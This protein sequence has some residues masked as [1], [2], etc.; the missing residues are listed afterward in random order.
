[1]PFRSGFRRALYPNHSN[2]PS[3]GSQGAVLQI[4]AIVE[5]VKGNADDARELAL[6]IGQV[7][8]ATI[9]PLQNLPSDFTHQPLKEGLD[10]FSQTLELVQNQIRALLSRSRVKRWLRHT[11]DASKIAAMKQKI[12]DAITSIQLE[13]SF[14]TTYAVAQISQ[15]Q[16]AADIDRLIDR[17]GTADNG[18]S[19]KPPCLKGTRKA[20]L[21]RIT[22]WIEDDDLHGFCPSG[23]AGTGK[24]SIATSIAERE[25]AFKR[26]GARFHFTRDDQAR[27]KAA[28]IVIARQ[29]AS[30][31]S[32]QLRS[33]I[34]SAIERDP[35]I[36]QM[37]PVDQFQKLIMGPLESL[38]DTSS[39]LVVILG[40]MDECDP[41]YAEL[42]L[43][44]IGNAFGKLSPKVKF[45]IASR[46]E[47]WLQNH[48]DGEPMKSQLAVHSL[49]DEKRESVDQDIEVFLKEELPDLVRSLVKDA[50]D[51]PGE[52][53]RKALV[54]KSQGLFIFAGTAVR[55]ITDS[56][57]G[58]NPNAALKR[59]LLS[60]NHSHLDGIHGQVIER[61]C[62]STL[63][64]ETVALFRQVLGALVVAREPI[65]IHTLASLL[66]PD[67]TEL[68]DF[69]S[70][71]RLQVLTYLQA[72]LVIPDVNTIEQA[73][74]AQPIQFIHSSFVDYLTDRNRSVPQLLVHLH[75]QHKNIA[76]DCFRRMQALRRNICDLDPSFLN[77]EVKDLGQRIRE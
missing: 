50:S 15:K 33:A 11:S 21:A 9:R 66:C 48:Y 24:S 74:D 53:K 17:L 30:W 26:L 5:A 22:K 28:I 73:A 57:L 14:A 42:L 75:K 8:D 76:I 1:M 32:G 43:R 55:I 2:L 6:Y 23:Q 20:V 52:A 40:A 45:F 58:R 18:A 13:T 72:V 29:L 69:I 19:K 35:D 65:N 31:Q 60:D 67:G 71:I 34:A 54:R 16:E 36:S 68:R 56:N 51:W 46:V 63:E 27:N 25:K 38:D 12:Q 39:T 3:L 44:L 4:I 62:P 64:P 7:T 41:A 37:A 77:S 59:I 47:P 70:D 10:Q 61:A 49:G